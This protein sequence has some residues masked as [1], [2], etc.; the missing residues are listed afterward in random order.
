MQNARPCEPVHTSTC[1]QT[2]GWGE[3]FS[4]G[5]ARKAVRLYTGRYAQ[6]ACLP[7]LTHRVPSG[8]ASQ[9]GSGALTRASFVVL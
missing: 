2:L 1:A 8:F 6:K 9:T 3:Y 5:K 7:Y 4:L